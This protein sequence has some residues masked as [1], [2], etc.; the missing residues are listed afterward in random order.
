MLPPCHLR[1]LT[2]TNDDPVYNASKEWA[3]KKVVIV[4]VPGAFTPGCSAS[5]VPPY[6][7]KLQ[8]LRKAGVDVVAIIAFN[9]AFVMSAWSKVNGVKNDDI[10]SAPSLL[11]VTIL[12]SHADENTA[13]PRRRPDQVCQVYRL[14]R[15]HGRP[16]RSLRHGRGQRWQDR[17]RGEGEGPPPDYCKC[18]FVWEVGPSS[19]NHAPMQ[20]SG[21]EAVL[22][23]L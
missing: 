5:H 9:D 10:V 20:V 22:S 18:L 1:A 15:R 11:E 17:V 23:K 8:D 6:I 16:Q 21:V 13:L 12:E 14:A 3:G 7:Q 19:T 4:S 2:S